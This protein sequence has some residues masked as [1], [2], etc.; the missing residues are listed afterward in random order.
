MKKINY[1]E[2]GKYLK[3][4]CEKEFGIWFSDYWRDYEEELTNANVIKE[5]NG[6][7]YEYIEIVQNGKILN[8][9]L[10]YSPEEDVYYI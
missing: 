9:E 6:L 5:E 1:E 7:I 10:I 4:E 3:S 2:L 8:I